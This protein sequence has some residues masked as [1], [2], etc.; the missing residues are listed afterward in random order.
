M[1]IE[2][3]KEDLQQ[4]KQE[5]K[6]ELIS[7]ITRLLPGQQKEAREQWLKSAELSQR[8]GISPGKLQYMRMKGELPFSRIGK[9]IYFPYDEIVQ[10]LERNKQNIS[11]EG[12]S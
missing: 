8:L 3:T 4:F 5:L 9:T 11:P 7:E 12:K 10:I 2:V 1:S 6:Q